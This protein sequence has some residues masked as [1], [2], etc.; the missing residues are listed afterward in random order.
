[1]VTVTDIEPTEQGEETELRRPWRT[2]RLP[3]LVG[4]K[5]A[6]EIIGI[7]KMQLSRW[8]QPGSGIKYHGGFG[9]DKTYMLPPAKVDSGPVWVRSD[10]ERFA[11]LWGRRRAA[12]TGD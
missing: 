10:V 9:P 8:M 7:S 2:P 3:P 1:M 4:A 6:A 11:V 12:S 5:S